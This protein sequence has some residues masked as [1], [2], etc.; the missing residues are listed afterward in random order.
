[1]IQQG[2]QPG[3]VHRPRRAQR[4]VNVIALPAIGQ[5]HRDL[6][7]QAVGR[8][9]VEAERIAGGI[10]QRRQ[11]GDVGDATQVLD[12]PPVVGVAQQQPVGV[13]GQGRA[14]PPGGDVARAEVADCGDA[15]PLGDHARLGDLQGGGGAPVRLDGVPYR[16]PV[17]ADQVD[18][19]GGE[20]V[21]LKQGQDGFR[22]Q[23]AQ[24]GVQLA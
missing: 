3:L 7:D 10:A 6:V 11:E 4:A 20:V 8:A 5:Q 19:G 24:C 18:I 15:R 12:G 21:F 17:R 13:A 14:L 23:F 1:M 16:L 9:G 2:G 22:K